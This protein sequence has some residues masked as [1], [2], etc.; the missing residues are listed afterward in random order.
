MGLFSGHGRDDRS[1][2]EPAIRPCPLHL[3]PALDECFSQ[4]MKGAEDF[5]NPATPFEPGPSLQTTKHAKAPRKGLNRS[6]HP[7]SCTPTSHDAPPS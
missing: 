7:T 6:R 1:W 5:Y 4:E 2:D 3:V